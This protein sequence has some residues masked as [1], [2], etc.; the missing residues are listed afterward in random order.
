[1]MRRIKGGVMR[2]GRVIHTGA[3][4]WYRRKGLRDTSSAS[5]I[6]IIYWRRR[7]WGR[8]TVMWCWRRN[9]TSGMSVSI[10]VRGT[11]LEECLTS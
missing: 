9:E 10:W 5:K 8:K 3:M 6:G 1:M 7:Y 2:S 11:T 4:G